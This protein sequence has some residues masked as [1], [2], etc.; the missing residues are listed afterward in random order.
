MNRLHAGRA[1]GATYAGASY[2]K[3]RALPPST[4]TARALSGALEDAQEVLGPVAQAL[5]PITAAVQDVVPPDVEAEI[6]RQGRQ[7]A[8]LVFLAGIGVGFVGRGLVKGAAGMAIAGGLALWVASRFADDRPT[9]EKLKE[10]LQLR[11]GETPSGQPG[12]V[13]GYQG[14][15]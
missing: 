2:R 15:R 9:G 3:L 7:N 12:S 11:Q 14:V 10:D 1:H 8:G 13:Q 5:E 4:S 6:R